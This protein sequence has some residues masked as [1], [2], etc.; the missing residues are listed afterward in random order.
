MK[1]DLR[2]KTKIVCTLGPATES[3][4]MIERLIRAGMNVAR[5]NMSH[6]D[7][8][9][10]VAMILAVRETAKKLEAP[11]AILLD[12][13][14]PRYRT[15][16]IS[17]GQVILR[18]GSQLVLTSRSVPGDR[19][20]VSVNM[21]ELMRDVSAG[22]AILLD[23][24]A[25]RLVVK[26][27]ADMDVICRVTQGG[28]LRP[29]RGIA[30]P[31]VKMSA[32]Y[33]SDVMQRQL[34]LAAS[35]QVEY[36][37][38]SYVSRAGDISQVRSV[39][40]EARAAP[41][42]IAKIE[43]REAVRKFDS[44]LKV[45]DGIMV[46]RGDLGVD[47]TLEKVPVV[48]KQSIRKCNRWGK[49]VITATQMLESMIKA[50]SPTRAEVA[51]VANAIWD[52]TDAVMLSAETAVGSYPA[53]A[54]AMIRRI[55]RETEAALPYERRLANRGSDLEPHTNDAIAYDACRTAQQLDVH[56]IVAFTESGSTAWR[57][58]K[59]RPRVPILAL[60]PNDTVQRKLMLGWGIYP[61]LMPSAASVDDL[62][63]MGSNLARDVGAAKEGDLVVIVGGVPIGVPG[64]TNLLKVER[65]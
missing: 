55:A 39:L 16:E 31:G 25:I 41:M 58:C 45:S 57:V 17:D 2:R 53:E 40:E 42:I 59:Y 28:I 60:T 48:Q 44:I 24:G 36:I 26:S 3:A 46:A 11:V 13:P 8:A 63:A 14:G 18:K 62:F 22:D 56:S 1:F 27:T 21:P 61:C 65:V 50:P 12:L 30:I 38:L 34:K 43:R 29:R 64:T 52:G 20:E 47:I 19:K 4:Q 37:A 10:H 23:D 51:D 6:G 54:V 33:V 35:Y 32:P 15:G 49:P 7:D 9:Q 5:I